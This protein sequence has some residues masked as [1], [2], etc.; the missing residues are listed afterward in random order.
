MEWLYQSMLL[1]S[2][3]E[4]G[5]CRWIVFGSVMVSPFVGGFLVHG[6]GFVE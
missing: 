3:F 4:F 1:L 5:V 6:D 2:V